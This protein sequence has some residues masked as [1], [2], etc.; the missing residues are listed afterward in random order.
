ME[1]EVEDFAVFERGERA[2]FIHL[3]ED[4]HF[5]GSIDEGEIADSCGHA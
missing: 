1:E 4:G 5:V 3:S 2:E